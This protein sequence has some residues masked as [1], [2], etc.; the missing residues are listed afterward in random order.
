[1]DF[2][3]LVPAVQDSNKPI[4]FEGP[5]CNGQA[6]IGFQSSVAGLTPS[7]V[8]ADFYGQAVTV[9]VAAVGY[10]ETRQIQSTFVQDVCSSTPL[11]L[12]GILPVTQVVDFGAMFKTPYTVR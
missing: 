11:E 7:S 6:Y 2:S 1:V 8:V 5:A 3:K 12:P 4:H 9:Y 10:P